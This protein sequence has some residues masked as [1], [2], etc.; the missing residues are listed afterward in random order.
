MPNPCE[1]PQPTIC[2]WLSISPY[3]EQLQTKSPNICIEVLAWQMIP[4]S[5]PPKHRAVRKSLEKYAQGLRQA[6]ERSR[7]PPVPL[8]NVRYRNDHRQPV[9]RSHSRLY[10]PSVAVHLK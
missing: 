5:E 6:T 8:A 7:L 3:F 10:E 4:G 2:Q 9:I 1:V